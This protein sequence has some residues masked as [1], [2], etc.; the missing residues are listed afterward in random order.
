MV[1]QARAN[2]LVGGTMT[3]D[4]LGN[5]DYLVTLTIYRDCSSSTQFD[6]N[7]PIG[8]FDS[9]G[10]LLST[11]LVAFTVSTT[12]PIILN[13]PCLVNPNVCVEKAEYQFTT[14][15]PPLSGGYDIVYQRC[16]RNASAINIIN[17]SST[18]S[19]YYVH[20]PDPS[21][22][23]CNSSPTFNNPPPTAM[24][25]SFEFNYDLSAT[26]PD[27]DSLYYSF[28]EAYTGGSQGQPAPNPP[29]P[30]PFNNIVWAPNYSANYQI[31]ANPQ[32]TIDPQT[33]FLIGTPTAMGF[34]TFSINI[35][36]YRNGVYIGEIYRDFLL[37]VTS[38]QSNTVA[39]FD[40]QTSFCFGTTANFNN[41]S[42]NT[43]FYDWDFGDPST[44]AD[45]S[46]I[47]NPSYTYADTGTYTVQLI[48]NAGFVC[49][50]TIT[51]QFQIKP[52]LQTPSFVMSPSQCLLNNSFS[53]TALG[54]ND[55]N[56]TI[57]WGFEGIANP[58]S[59]L[60]NTSQ[61]SYPEPGNYPVSLTLEN[62]G[63]TRNY[64]DTARVFPDLEPHFTILNDTGCQPFSLF[65]ND[66][67]TAGTPITYLWNFGDGNTSTLASPTNLYSEPGLFD[68][69]LTV[70]T[71]SGCIDTKT[72]YFDD[73]I[74]VHPK[75]TSIFNI[76]PKETYF[77]NH[78]I[79]VKDISDV[80]Y[81]EFDFGD[82]SIFTERDVAY[83]YQDTGRYLF[84]QIVTTEF[85]CKDT[86]EQIIWIK[87]DFLF[88]A[89]NAFTPDGDGLNDVFFPKI[90]G[91]MEYELQIFNRWGEL[92]FTSNDENV[93][94][95]GT[96]GNK[97]SQVGV[98]NWVATVITVDGLIHRKVGH[99]N[100]VR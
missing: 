25:T 86:S 98:Y 63:C 75:P 83:S 30:P 55:P 93:G 97:A 82:G 62:F 78:V 64:Y 2:H 10:T 33:G 76:F 59:V 49:A 41:T 96:Q 50:D 22:V 70:S 77:R 29:T 31:D 11:E 9:N 37:L 85:G 23:T 71:D 94:W 87:P 39:N 15:L 72:L 16:C 17:P 7:A 21:I 68:V 46:I 5:N 91:I 36:E 26:D 12:V 51:R 18:G 38:C 56:D 1:K 65:F 58:F 6:G 84:S 45:T 80:F 42:I 74:T 48:A 8:I 4:C 32:F 44:N 60:G 35:K 34:Y 79:T 73:L 92:F 57:T 24:C 43:T 69:T 28:G 81:Q 14:N 67:S 89:P 3:Y 53:F 95:D 20:I 99:I 88:F 52:L 61:I 54:G 47:Q 90:Q 27:G 19:T 66:S 40:A 100:L 13:N